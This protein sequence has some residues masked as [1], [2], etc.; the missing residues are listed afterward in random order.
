MTTS[1]STVVGRYV[2]AFVRASDVDAIT[3]TEL[4]G[5]F[6]VPVESETF[7][8]LAAITTP[9]ETAVIRPRRKLLAAHQHVVAEISKRWDMLPV[10]FGLVASDESELTDI[11]AANSDQLIDVLNRVSGKVEMSLI[12]CWAT[13]DVFQ[14]FVSKHEELQEARDRIAGGQATRDEMIEMGRLF[15]GILNR[16]RETEGERVTNALTEVCSEVDLQDA[17][18]EKEVVR[19]NCLIDRNGEQAFEAAVRELA[20]HY[21]DEYAF[22]FNGPWPPYSFVNLKLSVE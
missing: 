15:E 21:N 9:I 22:S 13:D 12:L 11:V 6:G 10:S 3:A 2:Y 8:E 1:T 5:L 20:K 14:Y 17:K 19:V 16:S 4:Q 18:G 7:G